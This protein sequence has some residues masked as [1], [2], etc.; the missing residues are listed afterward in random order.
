MLGRDWGLEWERASERKT[1][2]GTKRD[3]KRGRKSLLDENKSTCVLLPSSVA[4]VCSS[5]KHRLN[6]HSYPTLLKKAKNK[7]ISCVIMNTSAG[8][9][10]FR[11][12]SYLTL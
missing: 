10:S 12:K 1:E 2:T 4:E 5:V 11:L 3:G 7:K 8:T 9:K 6:A